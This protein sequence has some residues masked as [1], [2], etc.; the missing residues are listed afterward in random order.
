MH[1]LLP[2]S[3]IVLAAVL[4]AGMV[5]SASAQNSASAPTSPDLKARCD[6]LISYFDRYGAS[7]SE[8]SD[9]AR[10]HTRIAAGLDCEK[11]HY[12]EGVAAMETLLKQKNFDVP[13][14]PTGIAQT[15]APLKPH[16]ELRR[17]SQ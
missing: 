17:S 15:P 12:A 3:T 16:G 9:G 5:N 7:R 2:R 14:P 4:A 11:G 13:P 10:N 8:N 6:Q 1:P